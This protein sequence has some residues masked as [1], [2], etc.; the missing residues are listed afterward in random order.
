MENIWHSWK[1][2]FIWIESIPLN[3]TAFAGPGE[4]RG[5]Q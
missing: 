4:E 1:V 3:G 2:V 5:S